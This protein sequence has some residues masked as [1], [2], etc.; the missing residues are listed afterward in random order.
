MLLAL[1]LPSEYQVHEWRATWVG[2]DVLLVAAMASTVHFGRRRR[3]AVVAS[4]IATAVLPVCDAWFDVSLAFGTRDIWMSGTLAVFAE[5]PMAVFLIRRVHSMAASAP[6]PVRNPS[7][8]KCSH[9]RAGS[10]PSAGAAPSSPVTAASTC[11][12]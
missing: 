6:W 2:F 10:R 1:T 11:M 5:L 3:R 12:G 4:T 9:V 8:Q 7:D